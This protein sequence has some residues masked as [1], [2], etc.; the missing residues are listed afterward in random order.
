MGCG[1]MGTGNCRDTEIW[2]CVGKEIKTNLLAILT[3]IISVL[4]YIGIACLGNLGKQLN[5]NTLKERNGKIP[6]KE[7]GV[8]GRGSLIK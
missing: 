1:E 7:V 6:K 4:L 3:L 5:P 8:A 2:I